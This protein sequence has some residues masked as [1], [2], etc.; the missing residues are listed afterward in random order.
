MQIPKRISLFWY[1]R[2]SWLRYMT[3]Y[4]LR[5]LNPGWQVHLY[6]VPDKYITGKTW[7]SP[8]QDDCEYNGPDYRQHIPDLGI[9][10]HTWEPPF[11]KLARAHAC[12]LFQWW[13]LGTHGGFYC[14]MD[15]LWVKP[16]RAIHWKTRNCDAVFCL[17]DGMLAIGL[18]A[19]S[20]DCQLFRDAYDLGKTIKPGRYQCYGTE[21]LYWLA[22]T[23]I[24][25]DSPGYR[26]LQSL[27]IKYPN[28]AFHELADSV[29]YP[30]DW[31][32]I[33]Q[34]FEANNLINLRSYGIHW[35]GGVEIAQEWANKLTPENWYTFPNT[36]ARYL[37]NVPYTEGIFSK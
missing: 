31:R 13:L 9:H 37:K 17:E 33:D 34:I 16:L 28:L 10:C 20:P 7:T 35:F 24:H 25:D 22:S 15:V 6:T 14:D 11:N 27:Q 1:G 32:C 8:E 4:S 3:L 12:N 26:A 21:L 19:A 18:V 36:L 30:Y 5:K 2:M 23:R 29:V